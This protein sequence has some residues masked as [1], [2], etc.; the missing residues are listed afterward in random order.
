MKVV[1]FMAFTYKPLWKM[2]I[3]K[4]MTREGLRRELGIS[5]STMARMRQNDYVN[6]KI[7]SDICRIL[8]CTPNDII[9]YVAD[10]G[11]DH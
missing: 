7:I 11:V 1:I 6:L 5:P 9:E 4:D 8:A 3:D 10:E 2:L